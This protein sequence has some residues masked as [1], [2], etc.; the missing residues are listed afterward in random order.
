[1]VWAP[2]DNLR[3]IFHEYEHVVALKHDVRYVAST[4]RAIEFIPEPTSLA[5]AVIVT[6]PVDGRVAPFAGAEIL[7]VGGYGSGTG[8]K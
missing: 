7:T 3:V 1:M 6:V 4:Y 5:L 8:I 2:E